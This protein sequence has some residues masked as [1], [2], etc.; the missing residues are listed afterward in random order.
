MATEEDFVTVK[1][2]LPTIPL[3]ANS[4]R[5]AITTD[6]LLLRAL[7]PSDLDA[8]HVLRTQKEVMRW[9]RAGC[10]DE[11]LEMTKS[12]LDL[13]LTP[14][15]HVT[16]NCA[17]CLKDTGE[18]IGIGGCHRYPGSYGWPEIG[19]MFRTEVW[20]KG[21]ATEFLSAWLQFWLDLPRTEREARV[22]KG[23]VIG[24]GVV[25]EHLIAITETENAA[26]QR[27]LV[28]SG[29]EPFREYVEV[30]GTKT[31]NLIAFRFVPKK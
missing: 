17:I 15:D 11:S 31:V 21:F 9:T 1:A 8:L 10:I 3:P 22:Q 24:E 12:N 6:R 5:P 13:F 14:N 30:V 23:M 25:D 29:F 27:V 4:E 26:S 28:K 20:G 16:A 18:L 2:L 19:Y 7:Q